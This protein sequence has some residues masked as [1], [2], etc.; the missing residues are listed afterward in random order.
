MLVVACPC[1]LVLATP[2][3]VAAGIGF[4][5]RRG[6]LVKG[7][8][9]IENLGRLKS[10]VFDKT[11]TLTLARLRIERIETAA[12][13][14]E[15]AAIGLAAAVE[16]NSEHPIA[17]LIVDTAKQEGARIAPAERFISQPGLGAR[18]DGRW[19]GSWVGNPRAL[20]VAG[21]DSRR[22][23]GPHG[24]DA[25]GRQHDHGRRDQ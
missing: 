15:A 13:Y 21:V 18:T 14:T 24:R 23:A 20:A 11:G 1:A 25:S 3:A 16:Q 9:V 10:V 2:T 19:P 5:V 7:G 6:I 22:P 12:G 8:A 4:L 17:R